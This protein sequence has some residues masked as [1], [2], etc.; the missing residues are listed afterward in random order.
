MTRTAAHLALVAAAAVYLASAIAHAQ[1]WPDPVGIVHAAAQ[2]H[3]TP[4]APLLVIVACESRFSPSAR[5]DRGHSHGL[6]QL[7][8][9]PTGL[10]WHFYAVGYDDPYHPEQAADYLARVAAG[11]WAR[12]G[13]VLGRWSCAR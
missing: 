4:A 6:V 7:N 12:Q 2:N 13:I 9:L 11:E 1:E 3:D 10:I 8:D 5:G